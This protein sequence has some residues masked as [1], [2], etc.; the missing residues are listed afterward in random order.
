MLSIKSAG[1]TRLA[2]IPD[3]YFVDVR[4]F[5]ESSQVFPVAFFPIKATIL[6]GRKYLREYAER[7]R[8]EIVKQFV[9]VETA[10]TAGR[11][12][13]G[14]MLRFIENSCNCR[15]VVAEKTDRLYRNFRDCVTLECLVRIK[16]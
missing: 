5:P 8:I 11:K 15:T 3:S 4:S 1:G 10:K 7:N 9:D 12:Q 2:D 13:F 16:F 14:E 6:D